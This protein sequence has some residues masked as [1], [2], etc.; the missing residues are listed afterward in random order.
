[1]YQEIDRLS[2]HVYIFYSYMQLANTSFVM[3]LDYGMIRAR[4]GLIMHLRYDRDLDLTE[5]LY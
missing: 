3:C 5:V 2:M 4:L 1:M